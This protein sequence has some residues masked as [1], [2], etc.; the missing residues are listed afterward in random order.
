MRYLK[1]FLLG[2]IIVAAGQVSSAQGAGTTGGRILKIDTLSRVAG[3]GGAYTARANDVAAVTYNPAGLTRIYGPEVEFSHSRYFLDTSLTSL[4]AVYKW[5]GLGLGFQWKQFSSPE[6]YRDETGG[7][8]ENFDNKFTQLSMASGF[9]L[10]Q[11][12]SVGLSLKSVNEDLYETSDSAVVF[13]S[14]IYIVGYR[15]DTYGITVK[16]LGGAIEHK[17]EESDTDT[18]LTL[19]GAHSMGDFIFSWDLMR[20]GEYDLGWS[21]GLE[22]EFRG[23]KLRGGVKYENSPD[24]TMGLGIPYG[25]WTLD[26]AFSPHRDLGGAH[27]MSLGILF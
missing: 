4:S 23:V 11:R 13:D 3:V 10:S 21:A 1:N 15:G 16:N 19:A 20:T 18:K 24:F 27:R 5:S 25:R 9:A 26:Y 6:T 2:I 7:S 17:N 8:E 12:I 22:G 14:G